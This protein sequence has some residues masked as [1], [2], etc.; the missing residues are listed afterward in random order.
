ME[1]NGE[2]QASTALSP[3]GNHSPCGRCEGNKNLFHPPGIKPRIRTGR[4]NEEMKKEVEERQN[5]KEK[6][7]N[8]DNFILV[9]Q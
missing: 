3:G 1:V 6:K 5:I 7:E 4:K 2:F 9:V 8:E